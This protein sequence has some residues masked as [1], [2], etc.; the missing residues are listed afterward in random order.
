M[1]RYTYIAKWQ[2]CDCF[3][4]LYYC[5]N[6]GKSRAGQGGRG[7]KK[8]L[9]LRDCVIKNKTIRE[10]KVKRKGNQKEIEEA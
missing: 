5:Y 9:R 1:S 6:R 2:T 4:W 10:N 3:E 8:S 7:K